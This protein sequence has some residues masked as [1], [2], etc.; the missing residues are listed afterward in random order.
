MALLCGVSQML[1]PGNNTLIKFVT[2]IIVVITAMGPV[3]SGGSLNVDMFLDQISADGRR[4]VLD[5]EQV[6]MESTAALIKKETETYILNRAEQLNAVIALEVNLDTENVPKEVRIKGSVS[7]YVKKQ[8]ADY[9]QRELGI[10][11]ENQKW[12]S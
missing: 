8:L 5:G 1:I 2:G 10:D 3:V 6:A 7:P 11:E 12:I 9:M 4:A